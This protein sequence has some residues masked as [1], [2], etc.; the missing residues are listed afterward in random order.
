MN[1]LKS[2]VA[3][4]IIAQL[5]YS[6]PVAENDKSS[7]AMLEKLEKKLDH[8][9][10]E[11]NTLLHTNADQ[12]TEVLDT[13]S[14]EAA[15]TMES[16]DI[17]EAKQAI[18]E[19]AT[20]NE[21]DLS[22]DEAVDVARQYDQMER[23]N[24]LQTGEREEANVEEDQEYAEDTNEEVTAEDNDDYE[25]DNEDYDIL[26][27]TAEN[28]SE[29]QDDDK[30]EEEVV[31]D[32]IGE[33]PDTQEEDNTENVSDEEGEPEESEDD[34]TTAMD[35]EGK[36]NDSKLN[37]NKAGKIEDNEDLLPNDGYDFDDDL[38]DAEDVIVTYDLSKI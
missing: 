22:V 25:D 8:V 35:D 16:T 31:T 12:I 7:V 38:A 37:V 19:E 2:L 5:S 1:A 36:S 33:N 20:R 14:K 13:K 29:E 4:A 30:P 17:E 34:D 9:D 3:V 32:I 11:L 18:L 28:S 6:F 24:R 26:V 21:P 27:A 10:E 15:Q 23:E